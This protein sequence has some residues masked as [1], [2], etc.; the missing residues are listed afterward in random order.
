[1]NDIVSVIIPCHNEEKYLKDF[2][3][4]LQNQNYD[5][6]EIIF[7]N[8]ASTD[9]SLQIFND[10]A[11][12]DADKIWNIKVVNLKKCEGASNAFCCGL[13]LVTGK[14]VM[15]VDCDDILLPG[16]IYKKAKFLNENPDYAIVQN[17]T[18]RFDGKSEKIIPTFSKIKNI[19]E[20]V[21]DTANTCLAGAYMVRTKSLFEIY[22]DK[23]IP[24]SDAGQNLQLTLPVIN[25]YKLG[26]IE[27]VLLKYRIHSDSHSHEVR[28]VKNYIKHI[29]N[30]CRLILQLLEYCVCD[31]DYYK[32]KL[33]QY[34]NNSVKKLFKQ[35]QEKVNVNK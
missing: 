32:Q 3:V 2:L 5:F 31:K 34:K 30:Y 33:K 19:F 29:D 4:S 13:K 14:Y 10:W 26:F 9:N 35:I 21:I 23:N 7:I 25:R 24:I 6:V 20:T 28:K 8:D 27:E 18:C 15:P 22:K 16:A 1:M 11:K 17:K 12:N